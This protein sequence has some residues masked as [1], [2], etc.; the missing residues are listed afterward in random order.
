VPRK[1]K[2]RNVKQKFFLNHLFPNDVTM[3]AGFSTE[4][5]GIINDE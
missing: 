2:K 3:Q 4:E 5:L 1:G